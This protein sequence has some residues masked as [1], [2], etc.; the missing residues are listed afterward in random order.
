MTDRPKLLLVD[1]DAVFRLAMGKV[2]I[3]KGYQVVELFGGAAAV[4][5]AMAYI[6]WAAP[7]TG[8]Y[9]Q[10]TIAKAQEWLYRWV[11]NHRYW[12]PGSSPTCQI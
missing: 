10:P 12:L 9:A 7:F 4:N 8:L 1:D 2:F 5:Q 11:A 6:W 3:R